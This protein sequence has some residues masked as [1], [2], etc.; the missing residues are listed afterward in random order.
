MD[1]RLC[2]LYNEEINCKREHLIFFYH[3]S[4]FLQ[5]MIKHKTGWNLYI[6][7]T[8]VQLNEKVP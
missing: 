2:Q 5:T 4:T 6:V 8:C 3:T 1:R 7:T